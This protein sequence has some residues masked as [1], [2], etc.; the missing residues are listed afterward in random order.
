ML[1]GVADIHVRNQSGK[2]VV[3]LRGKTPRGQSVIKGIIP[4]TGL[5]LTSKNLKAELPAILSLQVIEN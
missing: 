5:E 3:Q 2:L 1:K 4:L